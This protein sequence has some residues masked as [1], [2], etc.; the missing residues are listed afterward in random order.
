MKKDKGMLASTI[1]T[2]SFALLATS[3]IAQTN[4]TMDFKASDSIRPFHVSFP[5]SALDDLRQRVLATRWPDKETVTDESQ[6]VQLATMQKLANYWATVYDWHKCEARL[7]ALPQFI[8]T[9]DGLDI[10]F[11]WVRSKEKMHC[12]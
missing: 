1:V 7:N 12:L 5:Q 11:I 6:G 8:A 9:I 10:H 4:P 2:G 3:G